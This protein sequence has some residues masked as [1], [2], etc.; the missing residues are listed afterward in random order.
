M[1]IEQAL[2]QAE[3]YI[4]QNQTSQ[5]R[6]ILSEIL[7]DYPLNEEAWILSAQVSD[8]PEQVLYCLRQAVKINPVSSRARLLLDRLQLPQS[9]STAV[10]SPQPAPQ[11]IPDTQSHRKLPPSETRP[12]EVTRVSPT[13]KYSNSAGNAAGGQTSAPGV[14]AGPATRLAAQVATPQRPNR[15][16]QRV[17]TIAASVCLLA[18]WIFDGSTSRTL[19][20]VQI[21]LGAIFSPLGVNVGIASLAFLASLVLLPL[22]FFRFQSGATQKW[23]ERATIALV[24]LAS[25]L[26]LELISF[27]YAGLTSK[28]ELRWGIWAACAF[29]SLAGLT[30]L[31]SARR[32]GN[33]QHAELS[34]AWP[35][36]IF[37]WLI[38][39]GDILAILVTVIGLVLGKYG[40]IEIVIG[41]AFPVIWL[42]LGALMSHIA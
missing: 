6:I 31:I 23:A 40:F 9:P 7:R 24:P 30:A 26:A 37:T 25:V 8:K 38:S 16:L 4:R 17:F 13:T 20:G 11:P 28:V 2:S 18:P 32:L 33:V 5:A 21:L 14:A 15:W 27:F 36:R 12:E 1:D 41:L 29:Y 3:L 10:P 22:M 34:A 19:N 35:G 39:L 42:L